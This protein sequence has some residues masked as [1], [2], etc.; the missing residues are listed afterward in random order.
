M[1]KVRELTVE[2]KDLLV[3]QTFCDRMYFNPIEDADGKWI[4]SNTEI[5]LC[6]NPSFTWVGAL[7]EI[8]FNPVINEETE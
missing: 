2:Q 6:D 3:G 8:D 7:P 4:I 5:N 1:K